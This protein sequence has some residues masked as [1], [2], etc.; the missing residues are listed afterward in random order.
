MRGQHGNRVRRLSLA[1]PSSLFDELE[2][3][4]K[5]QSDSYVG[6]ISDALEHWF[7]YRKAKLMQEGYLATNDSN[8]ALMDEFRAVDSENWS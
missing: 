7:E 2:E 6:I 5:E 8:D 4:K 3:V 1:L